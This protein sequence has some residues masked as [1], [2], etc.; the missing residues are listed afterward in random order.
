MLDKPGGKM[1]SVIADRQEVPIRR[2]GKGK[3]EKFRGGGGGRGKTT[4]RMEFLTL[5]DGSA[6]WVEWE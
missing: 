5:L 2:K 4:P 1:K 6:E 3:K